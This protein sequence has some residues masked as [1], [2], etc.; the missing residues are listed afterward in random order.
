MSHS[1]PD[2]VISQ[3]G[4]RRGDRAYLR[5]G[6]IVG[7]YIRARECEGQSVT[8]DEIRELLNSLGRNY[9]CSSK[10]ISVLVRAYVAQGIVQAYP[11]GRNVWHDGT[12]Y[13][14]IREAA[15]AS[16][17]GVETVRRKATKGADGWSFDAPQKEV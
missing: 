5:R 13:R 14:S 11:N 16:G 4:V 2:W 17:L 12:R 9:S 10:E 1:W 8:H 7:R 3:I 15:R 6:M